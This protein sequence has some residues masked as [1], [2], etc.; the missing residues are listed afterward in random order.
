MASF[1][2][3]SVAKYGESAIMVLYL[4]RRYRYV[5][6]LW[7]FEIFRIFKH[8]VSVTLRKKIA[9]NIT[10]NNLELSSTYIETA[11]IQC[12]ISNLPSN[13]TESEEYLIHKNEICDKIE[14]IIRKNNGVVSFPICGYFSR[15][16]NGEQYIS[17]IKNTLSQINQRK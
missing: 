17:D 6:L 7:Q 15:L 8:S 10:N 9:D 3:K 1:F 2:A 13:N 12:E 4:H 11:F 16:F 14:N 5:R